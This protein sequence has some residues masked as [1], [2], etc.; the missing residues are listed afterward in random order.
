MVLAVA[1]LVKEEPAKERAARAGLV[2]SVRRPAE[3]MAI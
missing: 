1:M 2:L 3:A